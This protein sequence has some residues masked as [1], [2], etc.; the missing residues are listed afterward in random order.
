MSGMKWLTCSFNFIPFEK[1][2]GLDKVVDWFD[3]DLQFDRLKYFDIES[4]SS[5]IN[6][7]S[8]L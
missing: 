3:S 1:I 8:I 2:Y 6:M 7:L 5:F 4:G